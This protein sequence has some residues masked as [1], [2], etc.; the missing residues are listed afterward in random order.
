MR[1]GQKGG[2]AAGTARGGSLPRNHQSRRKGDWVDARRKRK[3]EISGCWPEKGQK[4]M[5]LAG[6]GRGELK[7]HKKWAQ[8]KQF[9]KWGEKK[10]K[11]KKKKPVR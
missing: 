9:K 10:K 11:K 4:N 1:S 3:T 5:N 7:G 2:G 8:G 6:K